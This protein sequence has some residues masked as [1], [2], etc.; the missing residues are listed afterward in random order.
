MAQRIEDYALIGDTHTAALVGKDGSIDW[1]CVPRF[2][3]DT[4]FASLLGTPDHGRWLLAPAGGVRS[5]ERSYR[6]DTLVLETTFHTEDGVVRIVDCMPIRKSTVD[7][8]RIVEG[9]SG[10]VP[11]HMDLRARFDYGTTMPWVRS[12][13]GHTRLIAGPNSMWLRTPVE[14][15]GAGFSTVADF[16]VSPG[17]SVPFLLSWHP[18][19][20]QMPE[21]GDTHNLL[22]DTVAWWNKWSDQCTYDGE[23]R[24]MV[25]RS[26]IALKAMT[27]A[28]TGGIIAAPTTSLPEWIG[29]VRN[30]DYRY[31]WL[32]DSVLALTALVAG[33]YREEAIQWRD[34]LLRAAAGDPAQLQIMYGAGGERRLSEYELPWLP[35]YEGSK[36]VRVGNAASEQFQLDVYGEVLTSLSLMRQAVGESSE[37]GSW[38]FEVALL[39]YLE[40]AWHHP[41]DGI[42]EVRG[43]RQH[44]THSKVMAWVGFDRAVMTAEKLGLP[45][46][47]DKWRQAR[48]DIHQQVCEEGYDPDKGAFTQA[49]GSKAMDASLLTLPMFG[50]LPAD[51]PRMIGTVAAVERELLHDGFVLRY[52]SSEVAD[53]L[54]AGEGVFLPCSFWLADNYVLQ[55]RLDEA[56][57]LFERLAGL[58]NDVGLFAEEYDPVGKR[59][60]GNFPQAF[61][62]MGFVQSATNVDAGK[63]TTVKDRIELTAHRHH[64]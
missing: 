21:R 51:D 57:T 20:E 3:S 43:G 29:S 6:G 62:H 58:A 63:M 27:Y 9:V 26:L 35:G 30:W 49:Y 10:R 13:D 33:G 48:D 37:G 46:P 64:S 56:R 18:S 45:G 36:P 34:W 52:D 60:L 32:R 61:T 14:T 11:I 7:I 4:V 1:L 39:D 42:W 53:G 19:Y 23:W 22:H 12:H 5:V 25:M 15:S 44:F 41:D 16:V 2:D 24:D 59:Q 40:G 8:V 17:D 50:F 47:V 38:D 31:C 54:P 28:P 55:G